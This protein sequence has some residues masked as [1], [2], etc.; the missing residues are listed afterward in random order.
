MNAGPLLELQLDSDLRQVAEA[1][2]AWQRLAE[3]LGLGEEAAGAVEQALCEAVNNAII[4]A[5]G[6][7]AGYTVRIT[8]RQDDDWLIV[9][10]HDEGEATGPDLPPVEASGGTVDLDE[11]G[12]G[13]RIIQAL[14]WQVCYLRRP[15]GNTL[16]MRYPLPGGTED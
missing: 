1:C 4:H 9:R 10:I 11:G 5:H 12:R 16:E 15:E 14:M 3:Q 6:Q 13:L 2:R 8:V 7:R